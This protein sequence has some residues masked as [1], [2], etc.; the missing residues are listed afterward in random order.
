MKQTCILILGMH[1]S[2]TS[3][4]SGTLN[5]LDVYLGSELMKPME[6]N[7]KGFYENTRLY[8]VN[9]KLL[10]QIN[11][12]W[13]DVFYNESKLNMVEDITEHEE[14]LKPVSFLQSKTRA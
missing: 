11:S 14:V 5:L 8:K 9:E 13:D 10:K 4:L 7:L 2:G 3:A 12:R 6:Q 1:R